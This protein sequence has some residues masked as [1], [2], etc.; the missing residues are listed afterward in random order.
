[1][2]TQNPY[3]GRSKGSMGGMTFKKVADQNV[4]SAKPLTVKNPKTPGQTKQRNYFKSLQALVSSVPS[5][6]LRNLFPNIVK[7]MT[8]R[9]M[10]AKQLGA[11]ST[12]SGSAKVV[13]FANITGI[14][15]GRRVNTA[16]QKLTLVADTT[17]VKS[18][19]EFTPATDFPGIDVNLDVYAVIF[20]QTTN[21]IS[22]VY[23]GSDV[24]DEEV[25]L[26]FPEGATTDNIYAYLT[27]PDDEYPVT[28]GALGTNILRTRR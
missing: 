25:V 14:G 23:T 17:G 22:V 7:G 28:D 8:R 18:T 11:F 3:I 13:D 27:C 24:A 19:V 4:M 21:K 26:H 10:L 15:N 16:Y 9:S 5:D 2:K 1:M 6:V 12:T 20:N